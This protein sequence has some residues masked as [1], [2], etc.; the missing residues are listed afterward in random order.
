MFGSYTILGRL[1]SIALI[2]FSTFVVVRGAT[3]PCA[4]AR[5]ELAVAE[6]SF[7]VFEEPDCDELNGYRFWTTS[8]VPLEAGTTFG[9]TLRLDE[10]FSGPVMMREELILPSAPLY[11]GIDDDIVLSADRTTAI[12][13]RLVY[14]VDGMLANAWTTTP[15]DPTGPHQ[16]RLFIDGRLVRVF[17]FTVEE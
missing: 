3:M 10:P 6:A 1:L 2:A 4:C 8:V 17:E 15:G 9:W 11:W 16:I 14:P 7:G 12:T 13:E 5:H